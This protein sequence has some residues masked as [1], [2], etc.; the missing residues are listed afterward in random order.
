MLITRKI[1]LWIDE[2]E[3]EIFIE[4]WK[5]LRQLNNDVYRAANLIVSN[6]FFNE[7]FKQRIV[8]TDDD[9]SAKAK[10]IDNEIKKFT[11][12]IKAATNDEDKEKLKTKRDKLYKT[13]NNLTKEA[14][15]K[16][17]TFYTTGEQNTTYQFLNKT[18]PD[19]PSYIKAALNDTVN[20]NF[21]NELFEVQRGGR[22]IRSYRKGMPIPFMKSAMRFEEKE[23]EIFLHWINNITFR[24][25][26]GRDKSENRTIVKRAIKGQYKFSDSSIQVKDK[27]IFLLF[28]VDIPFEIQE[29]NQDLSVGV[30]LGINVPA[31]CALSEGYARLSI[32]SREDLLKARLQMQSRRKRLQKHLKI[33]TGG[34]G[35]NKKLKALNTLE[36]KEKNYVQTY[37]H[38]LSHNI[39]KFA[40]D[41]NAATIKLEFL[42]GFGEDEKNKFILRNW[43]YFQLQTMI[44][45]KAKRENINV[46][47]V[48]PYHTSQTCAICG[49]FVEGQRETQADFI[50]KNPECANKDTDGNNLKVNADYNAALN[51]A[52]SIKF[53]Q[54]KEDCEYYKKHKE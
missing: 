48:D 32:G 45:Y 3:K 19:M 22:S 36:A 35:R 27:K 25:Q 13:K 21:K 41:N 26:F 46:V 34:K 17:E 43:S 40:K 52:K 9:L 24:L 6:Q 16:A 38:L 47:K 8:L 28:V 4:K 53:V 49:N 37:N 42:E 11:D 20:R 1:E 50:C 39:V 2:A 12:K 5:Y 51:I 31:C 44:E 54:K 23:N 33:T 10:D 14:R 15:E 7:A 18:F 29:L 30:D